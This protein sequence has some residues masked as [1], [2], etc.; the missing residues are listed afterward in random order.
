MNVSMT[1]TTTTTTPWVLSNRNSVQGFLKST[2]PLP[3]QH[4]PTLSVQQPVT[5]GDLLYQ[6]TTNN[7]LVRSSCRSINCTYRETSLGDIG[8]PTVPHH[9]LLRIKIIGSSQ[10]FRNWR[11]NGQTR[12][13]LNDQSWVTDN[14]YINMTPQSTL[15]GW[16]AHRKVKRR[17]VFCRFG[18]FILDLNS[19]E[20]EWATPTF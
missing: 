8:R 5:Q 16:L 11:C 18:G 12:D 20:R 2:L 3:S 15:D 13:L 7:R 19:R 1:T 9:A 6:I 14:E 17:A 10:P 4:G